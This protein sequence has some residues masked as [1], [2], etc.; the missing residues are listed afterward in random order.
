MTKLL[1]R[2]YCTN[3]HTHFDCDYVLIDITPE[4][5]KSILEKVKLFRKLEAEN[6]GL[7]SIHFFDYAPVWFSNYP[8]PRFEPEEAEREAFRDR[9]DDLMIE[10]WKEA[11]D[12]LTISRMGHGIDGVQPDQD[13]GDIRNVGGVA[14]ICRPRRHLNTADVCEHARTHR[15]RAADQRWGADQWIGNVC[16]KR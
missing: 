1:A 2:G 4:Y 7:E 3:E 10:D 9:I 14:E 5:A 8:N 6:E 12:D 13:P 15:S 11:P 16:S